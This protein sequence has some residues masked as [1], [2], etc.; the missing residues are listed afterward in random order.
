MTPTDKPHAKYFL[1]LAKV[2]II[3]PVRFQKIWNFFGNLEE[4][5]SAKQ[6]DFQSAGLEEDVV[7]KIIETRDKIDLNSEMEN[8][9]NDG[10]N[11]TTVFDDNYPK[12][13]KEIYNPPF[14]LFY[15]GNISRLYDS[16]LG[17]VG[18]RKNSSY[19]EQVTREIVSELTRQK[20]TIVSGLALGI[21]AL[22]HQACLQAGG[23]TVAV[24]GSS[25]DWPNIGPS[26][27]KQLARDILEQGGFLVSEYAPVFPA[28]KITFPLRN[29]IISGL[30]LGVLIIEAAQSSGTLITGKFALEQNR[31]VFAVPGNIYNLT[32][33]GTNNLIKLGAKLVTSASDILEELN[34][35]QI[36]EISEQIIEIPTTD[37]EKFIL[38]YLSQEP[39]H[40]DKISQLCKIRI[41][42]LSSKLM[43]MEMN[44]LI[45]DA[46]AQNYIKK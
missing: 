19:G 22:A 23:V 6:V 11:F 15:R 39:T 26:T 7:Q 12:L 43:L 31:D 40:I 35:R 13:L 5:W 16:C 10:I 33:V 30:S 46:G 18:A 20:I 42:V 25:L 14:I 45:K 32:S 17:V 21:D 27:N 1:A 29:R 28:S 34:L 37:E 2:K 44:G 38:Q 4:A 3:G 24:L 41:S 36:S 9:A 8:L